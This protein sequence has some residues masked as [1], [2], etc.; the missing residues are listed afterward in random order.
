MHPTVYYLQAQWSA[1][2]MRREAARHRLAREVARQRPRPAVGGRFAVLATLR[3][4]LRQ[5]PEPRT[6]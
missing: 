1:E 6:G 5:V 4:A 2:E 3:A